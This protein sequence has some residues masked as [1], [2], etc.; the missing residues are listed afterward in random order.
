MVKIMLSKMRTIDNK[1]GSYIVDAAITLPIFI[2][3]VII[4]SGIILMYAA[5]EN[6]SFI[7]ANEM[8]LCSYEAIGAGVAGDMGAGS[9]DLIGAAGYLNVPYRIKRDSMAGSGQIRDMRVTDFGYRSKRWGQD[10]LIILKMRLYFEAGKPLGLDNKLH[11]DLPM[12]T[13]AYVGKKRNADPMSDA[14]MAGGGDPVY[15][16]PKRGEKYHSK[17]CGFLKAVSESGTLTPALKM[18]YKSCPICGSSSAPEGA[19]VY[20]F[21]AAGEDYHLPGCQALKRDYI[22]IERQVAKERGYTACSKC[23]GQ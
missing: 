9:A 8:R 19:L 3:A 4:L 20:Y 14:E 7:T 12:V 23:G 2:L 22:E 11:Y 17:G 18:K 5:I 16:F 6:C 21:P 15:I 1:K 10:E 13:R